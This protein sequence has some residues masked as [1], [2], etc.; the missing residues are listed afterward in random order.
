MLNVLII[1]VHTHFVMYQ[2]TAIRYPYC[3][4]SG[5]FQPHIV[6]TQS[7]QPFSFR[8]PHSTP[9]SFSSMLLRFMAETPRT[10]QQGPLPTTGVDLKC[11]HLNRF[12]KRSKNI[13]N[14]VLFRLGY[15]YLPCTD[16]KCCR[17]AILTMLCAFVKG[18]HFLILKR[19]AL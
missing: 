15:Y 7:T 14:V 1:L 8:T 5:K 17:K 4:D 13:K 19:A 3:V 10:C 6:S 18:G 12:G 2:F 9:N 11:K 16:D